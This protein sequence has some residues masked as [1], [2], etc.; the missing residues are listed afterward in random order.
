M[1]AQQSVGGFDSVGVIL[2][3]ITNYI[4]E[5]ISGK[6][7][8][9]SLVNEGLSMVT[10]LPKMHIFHIVVH[11]CLILWKTCGY[12]FPWYTYFCSVMSSYCPHIFLYPWIWHSAI[13]GPIFKKKIFFIYLDFKL[14]H[15]NLKNHQK[16]FRTHNTL[17]TKVSLPTGTNQP[18]TSI[19]QLQI[20]PADDGLVRLDI[21]KIIH[22]V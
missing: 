1:D 9:P 3:Y 12:S 15:L 11:T 2:F 6:W 20:F 21:L 14:K 13:Q 18:N 7:D 17:P 10:V 19:I 5:R 22:T 4:D 8:G 16:V